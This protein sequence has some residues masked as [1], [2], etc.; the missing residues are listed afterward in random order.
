MIQRV[1]WR[2]ALLACAATGLMTA[3]PAWAAEPTLSF[4]TLGTNS[5]PI[6]NPQRSE[7][8]NLV[9]YGDQI[10]LA[11][12]GDGAAEQLAKAGVRLG[13]V[14]AVII[15]HLHFDHTGGL[16]ALLSLRYQAKDGGVLMVYGPAGTKQTVEGLVAAM[17]PGGFVSSTIRGEGGKPGDMV[18]VVEI[19]DG[20]V[21]NLGPVKVTVSGNSHFVNLPAAAQGLSL[22]LR[23]DAPGRSIVYTGDTGPSPKVEALC[24]G[25]DLLVSEIM[26][27]DLA[28]AK[29]HVARPEIP[30]ADLKFVGEH[31][32]R[33][34][35]SPNEVGLLAQRCDAK[36]L[37]LTH[38]ALADNELDGAKRAIAGRYAGPIVF[39]KD[40]DT[41]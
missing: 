5:G 29:I 34:H 38:N 41:F 31:F 9:R 18:K 7:P 32:S 25:A 10:V 15:S 35:L 30:E 22:S 16:F 4:T 40:L 2:A 11:D 1:G 12:V 27:P 28:L 13:S 8:A 26:D 39:A 3:A 23:F 6:P 36:A 21:F 14:G 20:S 17:G 19:A 33:E 24:K 37:V